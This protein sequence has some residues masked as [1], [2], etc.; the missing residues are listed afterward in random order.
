MS[1]ES[2][3]TLLV[4]SRTR[5]AEVITAFEG[6]GGHH[7]LVTGSD[8]FALGT[9][10]VLLVAEG[11]NP[12]LA[13]AEQAGLE[14]AVLFAYQ[15]LFYYGRVRFGTHKFAFRLFERTGNWWELNERGGEPYDRYRKLLNRVADG[16]V[17]VDAS[18]TIRWANATFRQ[19]LGE[20]VVGAK[21]EQAVDSDDLFRLRTLRHQ[22]MAGVVVPFPIRLRSGQ[23]VEVDAN[24]RFDSE[25]KQLGS[26]IVFRG[27]GREDS[28]LERGRELFALY[29]IASAISQCHGLEKTL[30]TVVRHTMELLDLSAGGIFLDQQLAACR[31]VEPGGEL[32]TTL[33]EECRPMPGKKKARVWREV[34]A[35]HPF[36]AEGWHGFA[37]VSLRSGS[38]VMGSLWFASHEEGNFSREV[39]SLLISIASQLVTVIENLRHVEQQLQAEAER[40]RFYRDALCAVTQGKLALCE[41]SELREV[42]EAAGE[43]LGRHEVTELADVP[44]VRHLVEAALAAEG[45]N[46]DRVADMALCATEAVGNVVKHADRGAVEIRGNADCLR[47]LVEDDGP[48][49]DF[50]HLPSAVLT[51]GYSTAPSLGMGYSILLELVDRLHLTTGEHGTTLIL[52]MKRQQADPLDAF[53]GF[54]SED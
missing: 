16:V 31:G 30:R 7:Q 3:S 40:R 36:H 6:V 10:D 47:V 27:V 14:I 42:W 17:E 46:E 44:R 38:E 9:V 48:G 25:G 53:I 5:A 49:I 41:P 2:L 32:L 12:L 35:G 15:D 13:Q 28:Q 43:L 50:A 8:G 11:D 33:S 18:D 37:A 34:P 23:L 52:E 39:V 22:H 51:A 26:S 45:L 19:A 54:L 29:S 24:P 21:L 1:L 4:D 20:Q